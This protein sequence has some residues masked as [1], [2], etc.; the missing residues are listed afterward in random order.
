MILLAGGVGTRFGSPLPKQFLPLGDTCIARIAFDFFAG[1][2]IIVVCEEQYQEYFPTP[3]FATPGPRRQ[4]SLK[5]GFTHVSSPWVAVHDAARPFIP[6]QGWG[7]LKAAALETGAAALAL[8]VTD[9]IKRT[10]GDN[11]VLE[12]LDR[13]YLWSVQTP[14]LM[15]ADWLAHGLENS[16]DVTDDVALLERSDY[17][18]TLVPGCAKNRKITYPSDYACAT[19]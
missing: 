18:V 11:R 19:N 17:P 7:N 8:P 9:T 3:Y 1:H 15:R 4:D 14:Q 13:S 16:D 6:S 5:N 2:R 12:T 10:D